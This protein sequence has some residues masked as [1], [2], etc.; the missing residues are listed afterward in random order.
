MLKLGKAI[1]IAAKAHEHQIDKSG[2]PYILHCIAVMQGVEKYNDDELSIIAILHDLIEDTLW[3]PI[4]NT[5][6]W[7]LYFQ[8]TDNIVYQEVKISERIYIALT[9]LTHNKDESYQSYIDNIA[10]NIDAIKV[11]I[12]DLEHNSQISR[13]KSVKDKDLQRIIKYYKAYS[14]LH[15]ALIQ[16]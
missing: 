4:N 5:Y 10:T 3:I 7:F 12:S 8:N 11:K 9:L 6:G 15:K 2:H 14:Q 16:Y 13:L 1:T